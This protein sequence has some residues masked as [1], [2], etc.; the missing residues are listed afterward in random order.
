MRRQT[1]Q[2]RL[3]QLPGR[4]TAQKLE[5]VSTG[6]LY[7]ST[8]TEAHYQIQCRLTYHQKGD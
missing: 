1:R 4:R 5:A 2:R 3:P 6:Y 8:A 7:N